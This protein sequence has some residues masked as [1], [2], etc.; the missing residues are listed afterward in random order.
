MLSAVARGLFS[1]VAVVALTLGAS[2][3]RA[4]GEEVPPDKDSKPKVKVTTSPY[5][6]E[7][8]KKYPTYLFVLMDFL[9]Y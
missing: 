3:V 2:P 7:A 9:T 6:D 1:L 8:G 5:V 4:H